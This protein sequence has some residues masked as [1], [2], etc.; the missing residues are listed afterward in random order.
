[1]EERDV[2]ALVRSLI[3]YSSRSHSY[4]APCS[5]GVPR[6]CEADLATLSR[7]QEHLREPSRRVHLSS[8]GTIGFDRDECGVDCAA[9]W[10]DLGSL[11]VNQK[12]LKPG[13]RATSA[14]T[15][16]LEKT[17]DT[18]CCWR[19]PCWVSAALGLNFEEGLKN[20]FACHEHFATVRAGP[21]PC[22]AEPKWH[23][24]S[25]WAI[26]LPDGSDRVEIIP[27]AFRTYDSSICSGQARWPTRCSQ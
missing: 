6:L 11:S 21:G 9:E 10:A 13:R 5:Q 1:M 22:V 4:E 17:N 18:G 2:D 19:C 24:D 25:V 20:I 7:S 8:I 27:H 15:Y 14:A 12:V 26:H 23:S 16:G 3:Q